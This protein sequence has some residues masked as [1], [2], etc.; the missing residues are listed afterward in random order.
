LPPTFWGR[1]GIACI[2]VPS[3]LG[4]VRSLGANCWFRTMQLNGLTAHSES[5]QVVVVG[6]GPAGS[7]TA[8]ALAAHGVDVLLLDRE[9]FPREKICGDGLTPRSVGVLGEMGLLAKVEAAGALRINGVRI[10]A[11]GGDYV[12]AGF[13]SPGELPSFGLTVPRIA[14]DALL[15]E[16]A[17]AAGV[18]FVSNFR[19]KGLVR[20]GRATVASQ[21]GTVIGVEGVLDGEPAVVRA[22]LTCLATGAAVPLVEQAGL[23]RTAPLII[24]ATRSYFEDVGALDPLFQFYFDRGLLPGYGWIFPMAG[25]RA[26]VGIG[27]FP[28][29]QFR[30]RLLPSRRLYDG[31]L[32]QNLSVRQQLAG[33]TP[34]GPVKS[35][36]LRTDF[37]RV[38][39]QSDGLLLVGEAAGLVNPIN[40]EGV[41][42]ALESGLMAAEVAAEALLAGDLSGQRLAVYGRRLR[43]RYLVLFQYLAKMRDWYFR[44]RVLNLIIRKAHRRPELKHLFVNAA[45]GLADPRDG[46]SLR[47]LAKIFF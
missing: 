34:G 20:D 8:A 15:L 43:E 4:K 2:L 35:Y 11:P 24:R 19:V 23:L 1:F 40:G 26:N 42:F 38:Q 32:D 7:T 33:A 21:G 39:T 37:P 30:R 36:P 47:T 3:G 22:P 46:V 31:F 10:Y 25:G 12:E 13:D 28:S 5:A 9:V 44:E 29:G 6:A 14:L 17:Q 18:R 45:L 16:Q 27:H 41:D